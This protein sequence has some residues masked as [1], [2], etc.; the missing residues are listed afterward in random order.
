MGKWFK[1]HSSLLNKQ[2]WIIVK[3]L[4]DNKSEHPKHGPKLKVPFKIKNQTK[5]ETP[6]IINQ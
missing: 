1:H 5:V 3:A 6:F 2:I 4:I